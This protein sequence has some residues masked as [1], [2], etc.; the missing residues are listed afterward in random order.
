MPVAFHLEQ[1]S[2]GVVQDEAGELQLAGEPVDVRA[3]ADALHR[4]LDPYPARRRSPG[5]PAL[6]PAQLDQLPQHV[7]GARLCLLDPR[8]VLRAG[9]DD[10]V[11]EP[12]DATRPPS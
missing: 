3:E 7:V 8:D 10:V 6:Q 2:A 5:H 9:D 4:A 12:L 1:H 11:G